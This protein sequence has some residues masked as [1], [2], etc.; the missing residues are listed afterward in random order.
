M[1]P[2]LRL[3]LLLMVFMPCTGDVNVWPM[4]KSVSNGKQTVYISKDLKMTA[5][6]ALWYLHM[7]AGDEPLPGHQHW[8]LEIGKPSAMTRKKHLLR[9]AWMPKPVLVETRRAKR[10]RGWIWPNEEFS[11]RETGRGRRPILGK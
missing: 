3:L 1:E 2:V 6:L 10:I 5:G 11:K 8:K 7:Q 4:P 9:D